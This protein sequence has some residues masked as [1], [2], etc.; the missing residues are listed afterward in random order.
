[1]TS[2]AG[3]PALDGQA[4]ALIGA[5]TARLLVGSSATAVLE[6]WCAE[7]G[8]PGA[9]LVAERIPRPDKPL[10]AVQRRRLGLGPDET[11]R[12]R[13]VRLVCGPHVLSVA[14]NWYVPGRLTPAMNQNLAATGV[15][16]GRVVQ[17]LLPTRRTLAVHP[18][19]SAA[20]PPAADTPLFTVAAVLAT[21]DGVPFCEVDETYLGAVLGLSWGHGA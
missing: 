6:A 13:R 21:P 19:G 14:D 7:R 10:G 18:L 8:L 16:F 4:Q 12:Y 20:A 9:A 5:L 2:H 3:P 1:M 11:A 15:P 17:A